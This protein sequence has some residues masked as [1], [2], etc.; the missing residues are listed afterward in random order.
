[1][2][3]LNLNDGYSTLN[4]R[5]IHIDIAKNSRGPKHNNNRN[6]NNNND[7][8][9]HENSIRGSGSDID[10]SKFRGGRYS[11]YNNDKDAPPL[12]SSQSSERRSLKLAP[13]TKP[14][15]GRSASNSNIFGAAKPRDEQKSWRGKKGKQE[16]GENEKT[17][18]VDNVNVD[19]TSTSATNAVSDNDNEGSFGRGSGRG[20]RGRGGDKRHNSSRGRGGRGNG[21]TGRRDRK[22]NN[23]G[24]DTD[25]WDEA[26]ASGGV[27]KQQEQ[28]PQQQ[29]AKAPV[30]EKKETKKGKPIA[31]SFAALGFDSD[32]D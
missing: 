29:P 14:V 32:S 3:F 4:G 18:G 28:Q 20:G 13:R 9:H 8:N 5:A 21:R 27:Q 6:N 15:E 22:N 24:K 1:M 17:N 11:K 31:N 19:T 7:R 25:G 10:G 2:I 26:K 12:S 30:T 16:G 23:S